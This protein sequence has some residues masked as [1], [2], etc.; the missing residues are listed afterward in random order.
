MIILSQLIKK[1]GRASAFGAGCLDATAQR[2]VGCDDRNATPVTDIDLRH[3]G[4]HDRV[5]PRRR[6]VDGA[7]ASVLP[8]RVASPRDSLQDQDDLVI[9]QHSRRQLFFQ[10]TGSPRPITPP[11]VGATA[12]HIRAIDDQDLHSDSVGESS[13]LLS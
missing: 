6:G 3:D 1:P 8:G 9:R 13:L 10:P 2:P 5:I 12:H 4:L 11:T 7:K